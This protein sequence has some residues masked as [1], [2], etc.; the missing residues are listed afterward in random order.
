MSLK[1]RAIAVGQ[2]L[3][4]FFGNSAELQGSSQSQTE[5][6]KWDKNWDKGWGKYGKT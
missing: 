6:P 4:K 3:Q 2:E 5:K 1:E